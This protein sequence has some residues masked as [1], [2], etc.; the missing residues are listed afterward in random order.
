MTLF[1]SRLADAG[2]TREKTF[3]RLSDH[4][5]LPSSDIVVGDRMDLFSGRVAQDK[6][7]FPTADPPSR[8]NLLIPRK[9]FLK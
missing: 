9:F 7:H 8:K 5:G 3:G 1:P 4:A 6:S 2:V